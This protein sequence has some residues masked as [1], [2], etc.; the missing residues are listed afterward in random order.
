MRD[1]GKARL[2]AHRAIL[3][4]GRDAY[5]DRAA[6][7]LFQLVIAEAPLLQRAR[8][9]ILDDDVA[10]RSQLPEQFASAVGREVERD[11][12]LVARLRQ[13]HQRIAAVGRGAEPP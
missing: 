10:L 5:Q 2:G 9:E 6:I 13:P 7:E 3:T 1:A 8:P 12:F 11:A 4:V